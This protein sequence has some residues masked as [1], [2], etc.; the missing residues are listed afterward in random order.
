MKS[1]RAF[2]IVPFIFLLTLSAQVTAQQSFVVD[3]IRLEGLQR[4]SAGTIFNYLPIKVGDQVDSSRTAEAIRALFKTGF[5]RDVTME[6]EGNTLVIFVTERPSIASIEFSGNKT[7][8][9]ED[10][11]TS[12]KD[13]GFAEGRVFN[14]SIF[15]S[16]EQELRRSYF[17]QG[18]YAVN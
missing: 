11:M 5:F 16:V 3:E 2:L 1:V 17:S 18:R 9:T 4:I 10:L 13:V 15:D 6:R 12:L 7:I 8:E 14:R